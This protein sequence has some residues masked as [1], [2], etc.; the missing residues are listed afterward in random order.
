[1]LAEGRVPLLIVPQKLLV[2]VDNFPLIA[3]PSF[4]LV[5]AIMDRSG[6]TWRLVNFA[7][8]LL[9]WVRGG[10]SYASVL[11]GM[12][13]G[14]ISGSSVAD[15]SAL[16]GIMIPSMTK[17][18]YPGHF[19]GALQAAAGCIGIIIPPSIPM[20][21]L[22]SITNISVGKLFLGGV[23][24]G[25]LCGFFLIAASAV[26]CVRRGYGTVIAE[27]FSLRA[28]VHSGRDA[29]LPIIAPTIII[30][31]IVFGIFTP[32]ESSVVAVVY[33]LFLG[34]VVYRS[35]G[36]RDLPTILLDATI[37]A[38]N[39]MLIIG[40][41]CLFSWFLT[42]N[43]FMDYVSAVFLGVSKNPLIVMILINIILFIAGMFFEGTA[44]MI[45]FVPILLPIA[46]SVGIDPVAFGVTTVINIAI[47]TLTPPVGVCLFV[48]SSVGRLEFEKV[49]RSAVPF[50]VALFVV[51]V[52]T[53]VWPD[54]ITIIPNMVMK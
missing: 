32:T 48:A 38:A 45:M 13:M 47:G 3:I 42:A 18:G 15:T 44:I 7:N 29:V 35:I 36:I 16:S 40:T 39:V 24:P 50:V 53:L 10:L 26:V 12:L 19:A 41:S 21:V 37:S 14:G 20:I 51:L 25:I 8:A 34:M 11:T 54:M 4:M 30:G 31:G 52:L 28:L 1:L 46:V 23:I 22:G 17:S 2:A 49:A 6:I 27:G 5:G 33:T 9:G 43:N